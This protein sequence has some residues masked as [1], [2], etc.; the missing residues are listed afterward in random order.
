MICA[1]FRPF[2][3]KKNASFDKLFDMVLLNVCPNLPSMI[4]FNKFV[5]LWPTFMKCFDIF[6]F[7]KFQLRHLLSYMY[8]CNKTGLLIF[9]AIC[10]QWFILSY[11]SMFDAHPFW[12]KL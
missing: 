12:L 6:Q 1:L 4:K 10:S 5:Q 2:Q 7:D 11:I 3:T 9:L 8:F